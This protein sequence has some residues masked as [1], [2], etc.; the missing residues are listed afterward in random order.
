LHFCLLTMLSQRLLVASIIRNGH[1]RPFTSLEEPQILLE[2]LTRED[3]IISLL[4]LNRPKQAN[5]MGSIMLEQLQSLMDSLEQDNPSRCL[6]ITSASA[7]VF[8]AGADL[9]ERSGMSIEQAE[10][11]VCD[12]RSTFER[13]SQLAIPSIASIE[14][15]AVGGGLELAMA[16]D[17]RVASPD[18][19]LGLPETSLAIVPGAGGTQR[20]S[21]IVG[22]ARA[23]ELIWTGERLTG[24][25]ALECGLVNK[26]SENPLAVALDM[27]WKI[28]AQGPVAI[29]ASKWAIDSGI[30]APNMEQALEV[31]RQAYSKVLY[32]QDR[33]EGLAAFKE[34]RTPIYKG[35]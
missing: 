4:T 21:R 29:A 1:Y 10:S 6:V 23:K 15:V 35:K 33:L 14:G 26:V 24:E 3:S 9:K 25:Q 34:G 2:H 11:F 12:L 19:V 16:A 30:T 8:S 13:L 32:T 18:S 20:L 7:K 27:A 28:A 31:E 22:V 5:A 17:I